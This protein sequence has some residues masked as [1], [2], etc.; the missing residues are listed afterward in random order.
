MS[1]EKIEQSEKQETCMHE[2]V[3]YVDNA[4]EQEYVCL[5]CGKSFTSLE[6]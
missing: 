3:E 6:D 4:E 5:D 2:N 1:N